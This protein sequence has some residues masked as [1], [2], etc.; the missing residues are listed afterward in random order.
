MTDKVFEPGAAG[1]TVHAYLRSDEITA[2]AQAVAGV[3]PHMMTVPTPLL[4]GARKLMEAHRLQLGGWPAPLQGEHPAIAAAQMRASASCTAM[5]LRTLSMAAATE[6][7]RRR[8][9]GNGHAANAFERV[10]EALLACAA[11]IGD[12]G[13]E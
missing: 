9:G 11:I 4:E 2:L 7:H 1:R 13:G 8:A 12:G 6:K 3:I 10:E 5:H